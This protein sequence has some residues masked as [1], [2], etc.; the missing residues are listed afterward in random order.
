MREGRT[1]RRRLE[2]PLPTSALWFGG[3]SLR[4][5]LCPASECRGRPRRASARPAPRAPPRRCGIL[6]R[7]RTPGTQPTVVARPGARRVRHRQSRLSTQLASWFDSGAR[8]RDHLTIRRSQ[9][10]ECTAFRAPGYLERGESAVQSAQSL[11]RV[12][13]AVALRHDKVR[14]NARPV[15]RNCKLKRVAVATRGD[16]KTSGV[17]A[18]RNAMANRILNQRLQRE[19]GHGGGQ[20]RV[21]Y[22][23]FRSQPIGESRLFY[24][25]VLPD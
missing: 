14:V 11:S 20:K 3:G 4:S 8:L 12:F 18:L 2:T 19:A 13:D 21:V 22:V 24:G 9:R 10:G 1:D 6:R 25:D 15:I 23:E 5:R 7:R 16:D 17:R